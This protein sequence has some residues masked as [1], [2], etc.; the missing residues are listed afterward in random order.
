MSD[1]DLRDAKV[2]VRLTAAERARVVAAAHALGVAV[3]EVVRRCLTQAPE[4]SAARRAVCD[5]CQMPRRADA[6]ADA[7]AHAPCD[8]QLARIADEMPDVVFDDEE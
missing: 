6:L 7:M 3:G 4:A 5:V 2:D 1:M 8:Q